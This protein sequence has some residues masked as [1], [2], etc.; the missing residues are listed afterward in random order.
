MIE[1]IL[2]FPVLAKADDL[3][4]TKKDL[5][6]ML[7]VNNGLIHREGMKRVFNAEDFVDLSIFLCA[8]LSRSRHYLSE[9]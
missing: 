9:K 6:A 1:S 8:S 5:I 7:S 4:K 3:I 2:R